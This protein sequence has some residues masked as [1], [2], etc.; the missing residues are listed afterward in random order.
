MPKI[1]YTARGEILRAARSREG[2]TPLATEKRTKS[3]LSVRALAAEK[4]TLNP[5]LLKTWE[6]QPHVSLYEPHGWR[7]IPDFHPGPYYL[8]FDDPDNS[9]FV[10]EKG[11]QLIVIF[12]RTKRKGP[13][14]VTNEQADYLIT[15]DQNHIMHGQGTA[16]VWLRSGIEQVFKLLEIP[17]RQHTIEAVAVHIE[18]FAHTLRLTCSH[19]LDSGGSLTFD[20]ILEGCDTLDWRVL[21]HRLPENARIDYIYVS[22]ISPIRHRVSIAAPETFRLLTHCERVHVKKKEATQNE[23]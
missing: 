4:F 1:D 14:F 5:Q 18:G 9:I 6:A 20:L 19:Q 7:W 13:Y 12:Q 8:F 21:T 17:P 15:I 3:D 2:G 10:V 23:T 11:W 22:E 16:E